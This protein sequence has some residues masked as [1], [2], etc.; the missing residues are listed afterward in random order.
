MAS[1]K[2]IWQQDQLRKYDLKL[3]K[4]PRLHYK[5]EK[6]DDL[7]KSNVNSKQITCL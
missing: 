1:E 4:I 6:V 5:D 3:E 2:K 7:I